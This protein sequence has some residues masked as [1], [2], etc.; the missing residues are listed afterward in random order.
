MAGTIM[1][2][3]IR[4]AGLEGILAQGMEWQHVL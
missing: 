2:R 4:I 1:M 3:C